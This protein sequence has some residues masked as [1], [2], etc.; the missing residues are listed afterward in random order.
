MGGPWGSPRP[1]PALWA[2]CTG[3]NW[4]E[5]GQGGSRCCVAHP[6]ARTRPPAPGWLH[7][8][9]APK[10]SP[11]PLGGGSQ[12]LSPWRS[13]WTRSGGAGRFSFQG[14]VVKDGDGRRARDRRTDGQTVPGG[15]CCCGHGG[16]VSGQVLEG[17]QVEGCV[18]QA[19]QLRQVRLLVARGG[20]SGRLPPRVPAGEVAVGS[21]A[22]E[23]PP[24]A[25]PR[26][27]VPAPLLTTR[28]WPG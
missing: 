19:L 2:T 17:V 14:L 23:E 16:G 13:G 25:R 7:E 3:R 24:P 11:N 27:G 6:T 12:P 5:L 10:S 21:G 15:A 1:P 18:Q 28:A 9:G 8:E 22:P 4:E 26:G 20:G